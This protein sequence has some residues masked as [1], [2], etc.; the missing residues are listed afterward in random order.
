M[1]TPPLNPLPPTTDEEYVV[2]AR[3]VLGIDFTQHRAELSFDQ[4]ANFIKTTAQRHE[5][6]RGLPNLLRESSEEYYTQTDS[7]LFI[8]GVP[9]VNPVLKSYTSA[10]NKSFRNNVI[11]NDNF[12]A[13]PQGDWVTPFNWFSK[14]N[15]IVRST[16]VCKFIDGPQFLAERLKTHA[17]NH[18]L[19]S[20]YTSQQKDDGYYAYHYYVKI[21]VDLL[22]NETVSTVNVNIEIQLTTQ[23]QEILYKITHRYY[24]HLR[25]QRT[26]DPGVWKWE[27]K[28][29]RFRA[30]YLS[31][32]LHLL[33]AI[34]LELRDSNDMTA[35]GV[36]EEDNA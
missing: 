29:N 11:W 15:D 35:E 5:F 8:R 20:R 17:S 14:F 19:D 4:N 26:V 6:F 1:S 13:P 21:P 9:E 10:I 3:D 2:W 27:V 23:L 24:E 22:L 30:G 28:S 34:I 33:E 16:V 25:N 32:T 31:H 36:A 7:D 12:P 18:H